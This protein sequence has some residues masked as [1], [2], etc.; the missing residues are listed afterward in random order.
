MGAMYHTI[1]HRGGPSAPGDKI[2]PRYDNM[3]LVMVSHS[4]GEL[5]VSKFD[6]SSKKTWIVSYPVVS[7]A[8]ELDGL[9]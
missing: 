2:Y 6:S 9:N 3:R 7:M 1:I 5:L 4:V 8:V